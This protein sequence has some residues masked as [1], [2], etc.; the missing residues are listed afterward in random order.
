MVR[1]EG[2]PAVGDERDAAGSSPRSVVE[3]VV[4]PSEQLGA[5]RPH[6]RGVLVADPA[7]ELGS[8]HTRLGDDDHSLAELMRA[9]RH[10]L[11]TR[12]VQPEADAVAGVMR[13]LLEAG[14][15]AG[16][17]R[18]RVDVSAG[19]ARHGGGERRGGGLDA[20]PRTQLAA[21]LDAWP[22]TTVR[23]WSAQ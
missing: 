19:R 18:G 2:E 20:R 8:I 21:S 12:F 23:V 9:P 3:A 7:V 16:R 10:E 11:G 4:R 6:D 22:A 5:A 13:E 15:R 14:V 1:H 17:T